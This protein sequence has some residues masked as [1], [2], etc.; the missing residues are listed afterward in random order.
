MTAGDL[1]AEQKA[2]VAA[3]PGPVRVL[4]GFSTGKTTVLKARADRLATESGGRRVLVLT[5]SRTTAQ[6]LHSEA[7]PGVEVSTFVDHAM[8]ILTNYRGPIRL[9]ERPEHQA[10][11]E[12]LLTVEGRDEWPNLHEHL[13]H[14]SFAEEVAATILRYQ[15]ALLAV[16]ELR[17]HAAAAGAADEWEELHAFTERYLDALDAR[18]AVDTAGAL[19]HASLLLHDDDVLA[20]E[21]NRYAAILVD[22]Y[23]LATIGT[24]RLLVQLAGQGGEVTVTGNLDA[25]IQAVHGASPVHLERFCERFDTKIDF[26]LSEPFRSA[27]PPWVVSGERIDE[28]AA[29]AETLET[30]RSDGFSWSD[31]AVLTRTELDA[32]L[33][34]S[35]LP[36]GFS[37]ATIDAAGG[38]EWPVVVVAGCAEGSLPARYPHHR[39]FDPAVVDGPAMPSREEREAKWIDEEARRFALA[40]SRATARLVLVA[41]SPPSRFVTT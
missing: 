14:V 7:A 29:I 37:V 15:A 23:E 41:P 10:I 20:S 18:R 16:E 6:R 5:R 35:R 39:W 19:A 3:G 2:A 36:R 31:M 21:R 8:A 33:L 22:D 38:L 12:G 24:N 27:G 34:A 28:P 30:A 40:T 17:V 9:V 32:R 4:G 11:V 1:T 13:H 26:A 25:A